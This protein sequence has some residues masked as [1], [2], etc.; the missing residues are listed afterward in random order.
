MNSF[1]KYQHIERIG[2]S[3]ISELLQGE[4]YIFPKIDGANCQLWYNDRINCGT[5]NQMIGEGGEH[6]G[7]CKWV[8]E[9]E[10][11]K[12]FFQDN[13]ELR[14]Y[15]EWLIPHTLRTYRKDA[16]NKYYVFDVMNDDKYLH[17]DEYSKILDAYNIIYIPAICKIDSPSEEFLY[18]QLQSN[19]YLIE[20]GKGIGEGIVIKNYNYINRFGNIIWGKIINNEFREKMQKETTITKISNAIEKNIV[21]RYLTASTIQK[22]FAKINLTGWDA[23]RIPQLFNTVF[24]VFIN[25]EIWDIITNMKRP[26]I[27]FSY[28]FNYTVEKIKLILPELFVK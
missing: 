25:E 9:Q 7:F 27:N 6:A 10:N 16:W 17:Y 24:Y 12:E 1:K 18:K 22:E 21:D 3:T 20:N 15:G 28:L 19:S 13:P 4:C 2:K 8:S 11:I 5:R 26:T 23:K 14:L